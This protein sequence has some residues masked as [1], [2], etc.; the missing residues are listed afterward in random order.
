MIPMPSSFPALENRA[1][2]GEPFPRPA[3]TPARTARAR[4]HALAQLLLAATLLLP[5]FG[6]RAADAPPN[7]GTIPYKAIADVLDGFARVPE[8]DKDKLRLGVRIIPAKGVTLAT[9]LAVEIRS[10]QAVLPL[11][12]APN[13]GLQD[14]PLTPELRTE[15]P[16]I[17]SNQPKGS[18]TLLA[19]LAIRYSGRT[20]EY[21]A[22]YVDALHQASAAVK[23]QAGLLSFVVPTLKSVVFHFDPA[24]PVTVR[25]ETSAGE[26]TVTT[27]ADGKARVELGPEAAHRS[28]RLFLPSEPRLITAE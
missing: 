5:G 2:P 6:T 25:L 18:L 27:D 17:F 19:E 1:E 26:K 11:K 7:P 4:A 21:A 10:R 15:N 9:P 23:G 8:K 20:N 16:K 14:F 28:A 12:L 3:R 13:G 24:H 22:W